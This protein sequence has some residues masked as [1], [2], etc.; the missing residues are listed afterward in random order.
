MKKNIQAALLVSLLT[1]ATAPEALYAQNTPSILNSIGQD[2]IAEALK[3]ALNKGITQKVSALTLKDGFYKNEMVKI[4]LP[5]QVQKIDQTLRNMGME[6]LADQGILVLNRAA[7]TAVKQAT[8]IFVEA[9]KGI[10][11]QDAA[12][13]LLQSPNG[14]TEY[15]QQNTSEALYLELTPVIQ[16]SLQNVGAD[17]IW[18]NIFNTYNTLPLVTPVTTDLTQ[19]VTEQTMQGVF[20]MIAQEE[21]E[22]RENLPGARSNSIL[23]E[24]FAIQDNTENLSNDKVSTQKKEE[25]NEKTSI[26]RNLLYK[27]QKN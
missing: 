22:I 2:K 5:Q 7:E 9:I 20:T 14:A 6:S 18:T 16:E 1:L 23:K 19:Y 3:E 12:N 17:K 27:K 25:K 26:L 10:S 11:F 8:P 24:V 21:A 4:L 15:L 13:I